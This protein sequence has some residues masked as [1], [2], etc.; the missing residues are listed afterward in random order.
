M[1]WYK[2]SS[3]TLGCMLIYNIAFSYKFV[4][5]N[6]V[7]YYIIITSENVEVLVINIVE[8]LTTFNS[9]QINCY[10]AF[11]YFSF[12]VFLSQDEAKR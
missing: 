4:F 11:S 1:R 2:I 10:N 3:G 5:L 9:C 8:T 7:N 6:L 12:Y